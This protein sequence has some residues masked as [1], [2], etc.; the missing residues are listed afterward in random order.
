MALA[1]QSYA[2]YSWYLV[3][4]F[5]QGI[6]WATVTR[7]LRLTCRL[8]RQPLVFYE[9]TR[10]EKPPGGPARIHVSCTLPHRSDDVLLP[11]T[12]PMRKEGIITLTVN[13]SI[14]ERSI[15]CCPT[16][17]MPHYFN[18]KA[19]YIH[20]KPELKKSSPLHLIRLLRVRN[21]IVNSPKQ[22][23]RTCFSHLNQSFTTISHNKQPIATNK[24]IALTY[25]Y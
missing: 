13:E 1:N 23:Q 21:E 3:S 22:R 8:A 25:W 11:I 24:L 10:G 14:S 9:T 4:V 12:Q 20:K 15:A 17:A 2:R 7:L 16:R 5:G 18:N 19:T 6:L